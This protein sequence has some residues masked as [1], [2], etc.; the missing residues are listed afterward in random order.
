MAGPGIKREDIPSKVTVEN[1][2]LTCERDGKE[3]R[4]TRVTMSALESWE[5]RCLW[6]R[7]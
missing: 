1:K 7:M 4:L 5:S 3:T 6:A 2:E